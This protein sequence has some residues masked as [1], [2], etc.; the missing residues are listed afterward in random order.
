MAL[1]CPLCEHPD[2]PQSPIKSRIARRSCQFGVFGTIAGLE[3]APGNRNSRLPQVPTET[4]LSS[5][6]RKIPPFC[7][8]VY[9][10]ERS[11]VKHHLAREQ[12]LCCWWSDKNR[13]FGASGG[14]EI[15]WH[16]PV[17]ADPG[18]GQ[19]GGLGLQLSR[20]SVARFVL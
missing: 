1:S 3:M 16:S 6:L 12:T 13:H 5:R 15:R 4:K 20:Q 11:S 10:G 7:L 8:L 19:A 2:F 14:H 18:S 9:L 17:G